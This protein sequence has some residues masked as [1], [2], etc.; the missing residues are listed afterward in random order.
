MKRCGAVLYTQWTRCADNLAFARRNA[1]GTTLPRLPGLEPSLVG[2]RRVALDF[3]GIPLSVPDALCVKRLGRAGHLAGYFP[4]KPALTTPST[5]RALCPDL[6]D[7][8]R[9][10]RL[11]E[12]RSRQFSPARARLLLQGARARLALRKNRLR[13]SII[14]A[15][16]EVAALLAPESELNGAA[17]ASAGARQAGRAELARVRV[18]HLYHQ[19]ELEEALHLLLLFTELLQARFN[20]IEQCFRIYERDPR[21]S[22]VPI[23]LEIREAVNSI[24]YACYSFAGTRIAPPDAATGP[25]TG[26]VT[27]L[28][29]VGHIFVRLFGG[30]DF[31][32]FIFERPH[33][34][35]VNLNLI[36][37]LEWRIP[38]REVIVREM[39]RIAEHY[40]LQWEPSMDLFDSENGAEIA[41]RTDV[42]ADRLQERSYPGPQSAMAEELDLMQRLDRLRDLRI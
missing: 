2:L 42:F 30:P 1:L 6:Y 38:P 17:F 37:L 15:E 10:T 28:D 29:E 26:T 25:L 20:L 33:A 14:T 41:A 24:I 31:A 9:I 11:F 12:N 13:Q 32:L 27:E 5:E 40:E 19:L 34:S 4:R 21:K 18:E 3:T 16:R 35:G 7:M 36:G 8:K 39:K 22:V 23:P